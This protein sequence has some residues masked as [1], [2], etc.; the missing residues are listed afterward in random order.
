VED[1]L[2]GAGNWSPWKARPVLILEGE[3]WDIVENPV[4][5]PTDA[6]LLAEFKKRNIKRPRGL[7]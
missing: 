1:R 3:L 2:T 7:S 5:P 4:V 6:V